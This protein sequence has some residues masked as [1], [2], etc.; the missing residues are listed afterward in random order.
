[1]F[2]HVSGHGFH[3]SSSANACDAG[4][5]PD[6]VVLFGRFHCPLPHR[7]FRDIVQ[8]DARKGFFNQ[9]LQIKI[10]VVEFDAE[11]FD[12]TET[13]LQRLKVIISAPIG[14]SEIVS[15]TSP[16]RLSSVDCGGNGRGL[17]GG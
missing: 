17:V 8:F 4:T 6:E 15:I 11:L 9:F 14:V 1:M 5:F 3:A 13:V 16:P 10:Y 7:C 12:R 2:T